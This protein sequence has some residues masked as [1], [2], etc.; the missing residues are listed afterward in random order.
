MINAGQL[1]TRARPRARPPRAL[2][3]LARLA[4][5]DRTGGHAR[6]AALAQRLQQVLQ[7]GVEAA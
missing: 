4:C 7:Q 5:A 3:G 6:Q 2:A 1:Q